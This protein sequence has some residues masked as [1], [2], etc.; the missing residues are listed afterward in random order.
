MNEIKSL[1]VGGEE[2]RQFAKSEVRHLRELRH[3][4]FCRNVEIE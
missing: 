1:A 3:Q 2:L 4:L